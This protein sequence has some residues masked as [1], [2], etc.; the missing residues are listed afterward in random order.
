M[1]VMMPNLDVA[2]LVESLSTLVRAGKCQSSFAHLRA[3]A[4][5]P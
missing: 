5:E 1:V 4:F 3:D 2:K